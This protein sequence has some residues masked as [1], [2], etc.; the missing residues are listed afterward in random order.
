MSTAYLI[1]R[2]SHFPPITVTIAH[3]ATT[4][5]TTTICRY[6]NLLC[7]CKREWM[8]SFKMPLQKRKMYMKQITTQKNSTDRWNSLN[9]SQFFLQ[10]VFDHWCMCT[11]ILYVWLFD[12]VR[13]CLCMWV[14]MFK[15]CMQCKN[16]EC[17]RFFCE[18]GQFI[19]YDSCFARE[20]IHSVRLYSRRI[21]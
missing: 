2:A 16:N 15:I 17:I 11:L 7:I 18:L 3:Q 4:T 14:S 19:R 13:M 6:T 20:H 8:V 5:T 12:F 9:L 21:V 1:A 10:F